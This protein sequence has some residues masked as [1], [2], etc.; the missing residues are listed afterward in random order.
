VARQQSLR[1]AWQAF[2]RNYDVL[3]APVAP[4]VAF[5][6]DHRQPMTK[7]RLRVNG[8]EVDYLLSLSAWTSLASVSY[9]PAT[10]APVGFSPM[11][12]PIGIQIIGPYLGDRS[13]L[14]F[15]RLMS[16]AVGG[17]TI[18]PGY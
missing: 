5:T 12:L 9:L 18:P 10:T 2:F 1:K 13:T 4:V 11:K 6:H 3:L 7:R 17:F 8:A 16:E 15:A 14:A